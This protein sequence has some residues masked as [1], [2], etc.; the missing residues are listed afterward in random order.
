[1][2]LMRLIATGEE[3]A[4]ILL[5]KA[6]LG[7]PLLA[8]PA[9]PGEV[10]LFASAARL[11]AA[12]PAA[13]A[14]EILRLHGVPAGLAARLLAAAAP[15]GNP[16]LALADGLAACLA[17]APLAHLARARTIALVGPPGAGKTTLAA[18]L[19]AAGPRRGVTLVHADPGRR[20]GAAQLA[21]HAA[22]LGVAVATGTMPSAAPHRRIIVDTSG[23][24][25]YEPG[26]IAELAALLR[27][28]CAEAVLVLPANIEPDEAMLLADALRPLS[29]SRLLTTRLDMV[30]RLG[31]LLAAGAAGGYALAG[32]SVTPHV[33][34]G[35]RP[36]TPGILAR[37]L[38][39][40]ALHDQRWRP[41]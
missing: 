10:D 12:D 4:A 26:A 35:L 27:R 11:W 7:G 23:I 32:A 34:Y 29:I 37:R 2:R 31:G 25:P 5:A 16:A 24:N 3:S 8:D 9:A 21:E 20:G 13:L 15:R 6:P 17:F 39:S 22:A 41:Q 40:A 1:M 36:L 28:R 38:V 30:R 19:A 33:A 14:G 18:K